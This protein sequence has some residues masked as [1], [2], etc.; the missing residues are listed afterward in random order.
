MKRKTHT[1]FV[2]LR[3]YYGDCEDIKL[4]I[5][6]S[7][8]LEKIVEIYERACD[9]YHSERT[10]FC[11]SLWEYILEIFNRQHINFTE[12]NYDV[13]LEFQKGEDYV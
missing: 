13:V 11:G 7:R 2:A 12:L 10:S 1:Y 6:T 9:T 3:D 4:T 5:K 8:S